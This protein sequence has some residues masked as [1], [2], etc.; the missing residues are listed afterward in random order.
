[1]RDKKK[2]RL[3]SYPFITVVIPA[4]NE[5][6]TILRSV[7]SIVSSRYP[8][9]KREILVIDNNSSDQ[10]FEVVKAY[11]DSYKVSNLK[12][13]KE[14]LPGKAN[15]LNT[16][17]KKYA[18]GELVM[19]L[20]A[21]SYIDKYALSKAITY[22]K[23]PKVVALASNVKIIKQ[24][25]LLNLVQQFE[26]LLCYQMKRAQTVFNIEY[27][28]GGIGSV[29]RYDFL[30]KIDF[31][32]GD[33]ITEDI[34]LTMKIL[35]HG[36]KEHRVLYG[37][38]SI[39][40][41]ESVLTIKDLVKQRYRWKWGRCQTFLKNK[42]MF[43]NRDPKYSKGLSFFYL[44]F[45]LFGDC[46]FFF[47]PLIIGYIL[48]IVIRFQDGGTL[49]TALGV[50]FFYISINIWAESTLT[51]LEKVIL[52]IIAPSMYFLFYILSFVEYIA[53]ITSLIKLPQLK[54]S[55]SQNTCQWEHVDRM[56]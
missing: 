7:K 5:E 30:K 21:D 27:I 48:Y 47:E 25:T 45:A 40:Y 28:I 14:P 24:K 41:T 1:M 4:H 11:R 53:L 39:A 55:L 52:T 12:V 50:I 34:D 20:D 51:L 19:C 18:K 16:A 8:H 15:A 6:K 36:N 26:Y 2:K 31:Y 56:V 37:A 35:Q 29:F 42:N 49:L 43:F 17:M 22:F 33:T 44:P 23:D 9:S 38:D 54:E 13:I 3:H 32:D 10:T 46:S